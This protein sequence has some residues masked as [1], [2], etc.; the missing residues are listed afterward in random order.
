MKYVLNTGRYA[1]AYEI[2]TKD[3][4]SKLLKFERRRLYLDTGNV[5]MTGITPVE[6]ED[7]KLLEGNKAFKR[8]FKNPN[9]GLS[10]VDEAMAMGEPDKKYSDLKRENKQLKEDLKKAKEEAKNA[11]ANADTKAVEQIENENATLRAKLESLAKRGINVDD[12]EP[13]DEVSEENKAVNVN[14]EGF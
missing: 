13:S 9:F 10:L 8:D 1:R 4:H 12:V 14:T 11:S 2:V 5:A 6:D 7:Y 3:G